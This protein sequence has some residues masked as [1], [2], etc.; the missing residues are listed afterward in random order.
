MVASGDSEK[1]A[2]DEDVLVDDELD[3]RLS[4]ASPP[5]GGDVRGKVGG[6]GGSWDAREGG[7]EAEGVSE[8]GCGTCVCDL[9][10]GFTSPKLL[11]ERSGG[12]ALRRASRS[13]TALT[14]SVRTPKID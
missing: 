12:F 1:D 11:T 3:P 7:R 6:H 14:A 4:G 5:F 13:I 10:R 8:A 2:D 9:P